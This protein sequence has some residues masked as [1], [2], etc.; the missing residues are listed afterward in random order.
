M[1]GKNVLHI[2]IVLADAAQYARLLSS[3]RSTS[4]C[5]RPNAL[6]TWTP[7]IRSC[8][9]TL[10]SPRSSRILRKPAG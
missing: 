2:Q 4:A 8:S 5:S 10:M 9:V 6:M 1:N 7:E 3:N